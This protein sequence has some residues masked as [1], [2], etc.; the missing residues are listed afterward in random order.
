MMIARRQAAR[1][2]G[3]ARGFTLP[4]VMLLVLVAGVAVAV[5]MERQVAQAMT[6]RRQLEQYQFHHAAKGAQEAIEAWI[7][8]SGASRSLQ[9]SLGEGGHA[10][11]L[12]FQTGETVRVSFF[13]GQDNA[14]I[15]MAGLTVDAQETARAILQELTV[16][17]GARARE[18]VRRDGPLAV[19]V[20]AA[21]PEVLFAVVNAITEGESTQEIV[22]E[23]I[24]QRSQGQLTAAILN[25]IYS[26][27][28]LTPETRSR[29]S[30]VLTAQTS[31]WRVI[32][33]ID[34]PRGVY[35][36]GVSRRFC[37]LVVLTAPGGAVR[38]RETSLQRSSLVVSWVDCTEQMPP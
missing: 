9:D 22:D 32:A 10:F 20:N 18:F 37:G 31:L 12:E 6:V 28:T 5:M 2:V 16:R 3:A 17:E 1:R 11:D 23:I 24:H 13:D 25:D 14:L 7:R 26:R 19:S 27:T 8:S 33:Q 15:E 34:P 30:T 36:R 21:R 38:D 4:M 35:P 29:L